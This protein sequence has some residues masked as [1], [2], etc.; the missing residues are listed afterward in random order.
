MPKLSARSEKKTV[1]DIVS[2][3]EKYAWVR[4]HPAAFA[5]PDSGGDYSEERRVHGT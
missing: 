1:E 2:C 5:S 3:A 4:E